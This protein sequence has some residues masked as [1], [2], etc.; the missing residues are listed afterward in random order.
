ML[1]LLDVLIK[2]RESMCI[3]ETRLELARCPASCFSFIFSVSA[4]RYPSENAA[5]DA[6]AHVTVTDPGQTVL[7]DGWMIA[8]SPA[9]SAMDHPRY[10]IWVLSC[11]KPSG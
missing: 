3:Y 9:L 1:K 2:Q 5:A 10:D 7:F 6:Y 8:S 4:C 11:I